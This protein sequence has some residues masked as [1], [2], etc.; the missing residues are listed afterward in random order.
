[1]TDFN[2]RISAQRKILSIINSVSWNEELF[3]LSSNSIERWMQ[4]NKQLDINSTLV[5]LIKD[6][7]NKLFFLANK[8]QEQ[9]TNDYKLLSI[10]VSELTKSIKN[11]IDS[12]GRS[13][14][15]PI[16]IEP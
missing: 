4:S 10:E 8:S 11:E 5:C 12:Y 15:K 13:T 14:V 6:A 2:N 1:M 16:T 3:G 9:I 7:A